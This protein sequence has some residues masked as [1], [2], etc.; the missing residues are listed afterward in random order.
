MGPSTADVRRTYLAAGLD[1]SKSYTDLPDHIA[2][3]M[4]FMQFLCAEE[5]RL[6]QEGNIEEAAKLRRMQRE[7]HR[8]HLEPWI[9]EFADCVLRSTNSHFYKAAA[10][11]LK[12]F[13]EKEADFLGSE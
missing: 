4:E 1:I 3:E 6:A 8:N 10:T 11:V 9:E 2:A 12:E 7:F 5:G 13:A